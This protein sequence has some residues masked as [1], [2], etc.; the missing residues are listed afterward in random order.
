MKFLAITL[1]AH[2]PH[3]VTGELVSTTERFR[4]VVRN[5]VLAEELGFDGFGATRDSGPEWTSA[6]AGEGLSGAEPTHPP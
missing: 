2:G 6:P 5:A 3:P 4:E 1:I